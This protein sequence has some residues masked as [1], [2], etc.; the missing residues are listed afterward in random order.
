MKKNLIIMPAGP[1][2]LFQ[3]WEDYSKYNFDLA[4]VNWSDVELKNT[5]H[6]KYLENIKG[7]KWKITDAFAKKYDLSQYEYIWQLDDDCLTHPA[8]I[9]A[10]FDFCKEHNLDLAQPALTPDSYRVHP[11]TFLIPG[12]KMHITNTVEIMCPIFSQ[13]AWPVCS[14]HFGKMPAGIG[15]G[16]EGY[17]SDVL[18][19]DS[20][21]TKFGGRVAVIDIYPIKHTRFVQGPEEWA[22]KGIDP[23][24]DG[25][26]FANLGYGWS[27]KTIEVVS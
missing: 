20:G 6:A 8:T 3:D 24:D 21:T 13:R 16:M 4:I 14:E 9:D 10:T 12:A 23:N 2:A 25:R 18:R 19:S 11:P 26:Y 5:E 7:Q 1:T 27:F 22:R 15:Y 17:W